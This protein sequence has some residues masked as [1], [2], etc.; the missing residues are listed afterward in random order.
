MDESAGREVWSHNKKSEN[1]LE[2]LLKL[3]VTEKYVQVEATWLHTKAPMSLSVAVDRDYIAF[4]LQY[5]WK[6]L[7]GSILKRFALSKTFS[8]NKYVQY[9]LA[10]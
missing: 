7:S 3:Q 1:T 6:Y 4:N 10:Q 8:S 5:I 9:I 2:N